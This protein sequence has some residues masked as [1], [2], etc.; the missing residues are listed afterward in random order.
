MVPFKY[1]NFLLFFVIFFTSHKKILPFHSNEKEHSP[2]LFIAPFQKERLKSHDTLWFFLARS[3]A[4]G[5]LPLAQSV[6]CFDCPLIPA[7][8]F[9]TSE[10][11]SRGLESKHGLG[12]FV[13]RPDEREWNSICNRAQMVPTTLPRS[14]QS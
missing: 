13:V 11:A 8:Q 12:R 9:H 5:H 10:K 1:A 4:Y 3:G 14:F 6:S 2:I 7:V